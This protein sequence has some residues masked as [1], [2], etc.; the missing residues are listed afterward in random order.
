MDST[1]PAPRVPGALRWSAVG[2]VVG[3]GVTAVTLVALLALVGW[4]ERHVMIRDSHRCARPRRVRYSNSTTGVVVFCSGDPLH[5][6]SNN[7][8]V[9][10]W[11]DPAVE[12]RR[13]YGVGPSLHGWTTTFARDAGLGALLGD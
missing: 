9:I 10:S 13:T 2:R 3:R 11:V 5:P 4:P 7:G 1:I 12:S 6:C 8:Q